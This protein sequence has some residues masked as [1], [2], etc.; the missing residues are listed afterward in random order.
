MTSST[1]APLPEIPADRS[2][3][4][5][6]ETTEF[7]GVLLYRIQAIRDVP[8]R[9]KKG[10]IGGFICHPSNLSGN[11]WVFDQGRV[12]EYAHVYGNAGVYDS[13]EVGDNAIVCDNAQIR[14]EAYIIGFSRIG[15]NAKIGGHVLVAGQTH[16]GGDAW[17]TADD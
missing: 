11:A 7:N 13:A 5:T 4:F 10:D 15:G 14:G 1:S 16:L 2:Y 8:P 12:S 3:V 17:I 6:G 9:V